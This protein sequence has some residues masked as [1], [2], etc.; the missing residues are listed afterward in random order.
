MVAAWEDHLYGLQKK[1]EVSDRIKFYI[2]EFGMTGGGNFNLV[3]ANAPNPAAALVFMNWLNSAEVQT[4]LNEV[5][6]AAP[7]HPDADDSKALV[8]MAMRAYSVVSPGN[9]FNTELRASFV[10]NVALE[11]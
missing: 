6:G 1:G 10:E 2:P 7:M 5:F 4:K 3:P 8:P 9:P 11:R